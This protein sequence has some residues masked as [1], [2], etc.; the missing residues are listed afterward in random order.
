MYIFHNWI[1]ENETMAGCT[2]MEP[3]N[4]QMLAEWLDEN[5]DP[6]LIQLTKPL[7]YELLHQW[8]LPKL[9]FETN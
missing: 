6:V 8:K 2:A 1:H 3:S 5:K 9:N 7:H 4:M